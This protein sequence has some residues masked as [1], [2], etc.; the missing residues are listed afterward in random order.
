MKL[1]DE[2]AARDV[3]KTVVAL[4]LLR[5]A[6]PRRFRSDRA[7]Q[8]QLQRRVRALAPISQGTYWD[9]KTGKVKKVFRDHTPRTLEQIGVWLQQL[10][11]PVGVHFERLL[12][13]EEE[14]KRKAAED[15]RVVLATLR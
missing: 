10:F 2:V 3:W 4:Y 13:R 15:F 1:A 12:D 7:F 5:R 9:E 11:G 8:F 6:D 14:S